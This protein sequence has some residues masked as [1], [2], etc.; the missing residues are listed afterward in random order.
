MVKGHY[1]HF[2]F[3]A[4]LI[5]KRLDSCR[6]C[7]WLWILSQADITGLLDSD[8]KRCSSRISKYDLKEEKLKLRSNEIAN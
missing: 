5:I 2:S 6:S 3:Q 4:I 7:H 1:W 8:R